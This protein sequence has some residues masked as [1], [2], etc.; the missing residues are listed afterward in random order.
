MITVN[1]CEYK[2]LVFS[3]GEVHVNISGVQM[4]PKNR[5]FA[6]LRNSNDIMELLLVCNAIKETGRGLS[7]LEIPYIPYARQDRVCSEGDAFSLK[8]FAEL[9]NNLGFEKIIGWDAHSDVTGALINNYKNIP[10]EIIIPDELGMSVDY[11]CIP[12]AGAIKKSFNVQKVLDI[13]KS[14]LATKHR[15]LITGEI[16]HTEIYCDD[17]KNRDILIVDDICDGGRTFIEL[18]KKLR[19]KG[20]GKIKL[21]ITHGIFSKGIDVF[22]GWIDQIFTTQSMCNIKHDRLTIIGGED[23]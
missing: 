22:D 1:Q 18:A 3:G 4:Y 11:I 21:F 13:K 8:V 19:K 15:D 7:I 10:Q 20:A 23:V 5:I 12:D 9:I 16:T 6:L 14:I 2:S 17:L